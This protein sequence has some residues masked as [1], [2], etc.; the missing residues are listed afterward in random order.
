MNSMFTVT[1]SKRLNLT[2]NVSCDHGY[3][4]PAHI[5]P[6]QTNIIYQTVYVPILHYEDYL[7]AYSCIICGHDY[8]FIDTNSRGVARGKCMW[9]Q[10]R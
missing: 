10:G 1:V 5:S 4:E 7:E 2:H 8:D 3:S 9:N 6:F